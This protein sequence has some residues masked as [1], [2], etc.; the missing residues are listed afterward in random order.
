[1]KSLISVGG[2]VYAELG[3]KTTGRIKQSTEGHNIITDVGLD[4]LAS[5][6]KNDA[7]FAFPSHAAV[8]DSAQAP[9]AGDTALVGTEFAR[10]AFTS[11]SRSSNV[12]TYE[13]KFDGTWTGTVEEAGLFNASSG[14]D[15]LCRFLTGTFDKSSNDYL[16]IIWKLTI[17]R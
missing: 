2:Y 17:S 5:Y 13:T 11:E 7:A 6:I 1:M 12:N 8:G 16:T 10:L 3:D 15:M 14:G 4:M 9:A